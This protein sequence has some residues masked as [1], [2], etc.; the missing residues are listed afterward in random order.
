MQEFKVVAIGSEG[1]FSYFALAHSLFQAQERNPIWTSEDRSATWKHMCSC[2]GS[3]NFVLRE[4][5]CW[6]V[7]LW[8]AKTP[9]W[10]MSSGWRPPSPRGLRLPLRA[11]MGQACPLLWHLAFM[12]AAAQMWDATDFARSPIA[13]PEATHMHVAYTVLRAS[14]R[15]AQYTTR[16]RPLQFFKVP[17]SY[18]QC[19][20]ARLLPTLFYGNPSS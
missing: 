7:I 10:V 4:E 5:N 6:C 14:F 15:C 16:V 8:A 20:T 12:P 17:I 3:L 9:A 1:G 13:A 11:R 19:C 18:A 2:L